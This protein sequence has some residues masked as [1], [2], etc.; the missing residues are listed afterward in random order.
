MPLPMP[1]SATV[2]QLSFLACSEP[3]TVATQPD[4]A[5]RRQD[6]VSTLSGGTPRA[7]GLT[8]L[9]CGGTY[10]T[11]LRTHRIHAGT[12]KE[13]S[14]A[15]VALLRNAGYTRSSTHYMYLN[16][17]VP[18]THR[19][20]YEVHVHSNHSYTPREARVP[21]HLPETE[22]SLWVSELC[23]ILPNSL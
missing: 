3:R 19:L 16:G 2:P 6:P 8:T 11:L 18:S 15:V 4:P 5:A 22:P 12:T 9:D 14:D 1:Q 21:R 7:Y 23:E 17:F 20:E 13:A 10:G